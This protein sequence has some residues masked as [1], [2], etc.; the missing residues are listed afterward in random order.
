MFDLFGKKAKRQEHLEKC[1]RELSPYIA[2]GLMRV[3][4][5]T[6]DFT[7]VFIVNSTYVV[8]VHSAIDKTNNLTAALGFRGSEFKMFM[9]EPTMESLKWFNYACQKQGMNRAFT[10][11]PKL[12]DKFREMK[13]KLDAQQKI[14]VD[15]DLEKRLVAEA[16]RKYPHIG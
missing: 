10:F 12:A 9:E 13:K 1:N 6:T 16:K 7:V 14:E 5:Q 2:E 8:F 4:F 3:V 11:D 15:L